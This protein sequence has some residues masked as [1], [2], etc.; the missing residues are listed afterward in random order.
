M[1]EGSLERSVSIPVGVVVAREEAANPWQDYIWRPVGLLIGAQ[2]ND[3]WRELD[4]EPGVIRYFAGTVAL[5]L[6]AK[7]T[8]AYL[9]NLQNKKPVVYVVMREA[10]DDDAPHPV[11][12]HI[13]TV[14]AFE[15]QDYLDSGEEVVEPLAMPQTLIAWVDRF[16]EH[17]HV[18]EKFIKRKRDKLDLK[19]HRF[20]KE[21]IFVQSGR[22]SA[23]VR[24]GNG[25]DKGE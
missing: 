3:G 6:H 18:E 11:E 10:E 1:V 24:N 23:G 9:V 5:E 20:G 13:A 4:R 14:S 12:I 22:V 15:A 7:E 25:F 8:E 17:H 21:P 2:T 19:D 16:V